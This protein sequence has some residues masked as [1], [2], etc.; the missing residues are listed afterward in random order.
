MH[1]AIMKIAAARTARR[2]HHAEQTQALWEERRR[3]ARRSV[4]GEPFRLL[5]G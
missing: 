5:R 1:T 4:P 3:L 2:R